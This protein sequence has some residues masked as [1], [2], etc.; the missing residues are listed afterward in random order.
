[1]R[2]E[3]GWYIDASGKHHLTSDGTNTRT[4]DLAGHGTAIGI[5]TFEYDDHGR[6]TKYKNAGTLTR[7]YLYAARGE[8]V[9]R[10]HTPTPANDMV[11][12]YDEAGH[13]IGEYRKDGTR[14]RETVWVDDT[15]VAVLS[16][17]VQKLAAVGS[18]PLAAPN[19]HWFVMFL[20]WLAKSY[21]E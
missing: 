13:L 17:G 7:E 8:R 15:P 10:W 9:A 4:Y 6:A 11:F 2:A 14:I 16:R 20:R 18:S 1:M 19:T 21:R 12:V 3:C 5:R